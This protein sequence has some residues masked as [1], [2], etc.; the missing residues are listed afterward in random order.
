MTRTIAI[1]GG[2]L[3]GTLTAVH[4]MRRAVEDDLRI[5]LINRSGWLARGVA[6]GTRSADH[7]LNVPAARMSAF[8]SDEGHF[9]RYAQQHDPGLT[10]GSFVRR[11]LYGDYLEWTLHREH[12]AL[13]QPQRFKHLSEHVQSIEMDGDE[14]ATLHF[15]DS[16]PLRADRVVLALGHFAPADPHLDNPD[17]LKN[18]RYVRD[19]WAGDA[20]ARIAADEPVLLMGT[21]LTMVDIALALQARGHHG[22]LLALSRRGLLPQPHR[23]GGAPPMGITLPDDLLAGT[24][25]LRHWLHVIRSQC[26]T[27]AGHGIDWRETLASLRN[28]TPDLW[29]RLPERQRAQFLRHLQ[30]Y[31]DVHR[32]R[33]APSLNERLQALLQEGRLKVHAARLVSMQAQGHRASDLLDVTYR[34]RGRSTPVTVEVGHVI[35][36]TG[37]STNLRQ[38]REPLMQS[39]LASGLAVQD[40]LGLGLAVNG[41]YSLQSADGSAS[42]VLRY[43]GPFLRARYW[44]CTAVPELRRHA[45]MLADVL[46]TERV[47]ELVA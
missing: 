26:D 16:A 35:N 42:P 27:L 9:L 8:E 22:P 6:Y 36:C 40:T 7:V 45:R 12:A 29:Q 2:G 38:A 4:L 39:L 31:W 14:A 28:V 18:P 23:T 20:L 41:D 11:E 32:H 15:K 47:G 3:S 33:L 1:V 25:N 44:E 46:S 19:P 34:P 43:I 21:G 24:P 30:A 37:A 10:G 5:V 13:A 17:E